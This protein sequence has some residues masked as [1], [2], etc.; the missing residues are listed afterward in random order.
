MSKP[1]KPAGRKGPA[2]RNTQSWWP[3]VLG[4]GVVVATIAFLI[5]THRGSTLPGAPADGGGTK[6][7]GLAVGATAPVVPLK[8]TQGTTVSF[9]QMKGSKIVVYFYE[10]SG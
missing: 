5:A 2:A 4:A 10:S 7:R 9:D 3:Y 6:E 8:S 1:A